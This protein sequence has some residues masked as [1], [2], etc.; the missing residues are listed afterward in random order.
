[1]YAI[2]DPF[3]W[4]LIIELFILGVI[5]IHAELSYNIVYRITLSLRIGLS[6]ALFFI[7]GGTYSTT[8]IVEKDGEVIEEY[9]I[10]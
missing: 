8:I 1:M 6:F 4:I 9:R 10:G 5:F 3:F 7:S 2:N